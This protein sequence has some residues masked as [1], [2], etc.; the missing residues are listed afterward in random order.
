MSILAKI[1]AQRSYE[2]HF[3]I[4]WFNRLPKSNFKFINV[5][6]WYHSPTPTSMEFSGPLEIVNTGT[7]TTEK[8]SKIIST[9]TFIYEYLKNLYI[10]KKSCYINLCY[11]SIKISLPPL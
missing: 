10:F 2:M 9:T 4:Y 6:P 3:Q 7:C 1:C 11:K 8:G 5:R